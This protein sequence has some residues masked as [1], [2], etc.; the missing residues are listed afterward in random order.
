MTTSDT[1]LNNLII[2]KLTKQQYES[3]TTPVST[4]LYMV[5]D[6]VV[7]G[8]DITN[9]LGY[10]PADNT[11]SNVSSI[12]GSSAV[13]TALNGKAD[14]N[15]SNLSTTGKEVLDG[16]WVNNKQVIV[17]SVTSL[18]GSTNL[19][20][21]VQVPDDG[22]VYEV[23]LRGE[24]ETGSSSGNYCILSIQSNQLTSDW[25][26]ICGNRTRTT[27]SVGAQGSIIIPISRANNNLTVRRNSG[28]QGS[29]PANGLA[30]LAYR[31]VGTNS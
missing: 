23:L 5:T 18:N 4:E 8:S 10:T 6:E 1:N 11:L 29:I 30:M 15:L 28:Y 9:A 3:I 12:N 25:A 16:Q 2:N 22:H 26:F 19:T 17:S 24:V 21:T 31:R 14:T 27:S 13:Q 7:S 20:Y